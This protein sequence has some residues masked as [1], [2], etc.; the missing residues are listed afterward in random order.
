MG[1]IHILRGEL[2]QGQDMLFEALDRYNMKSDELKACVDYVC[3]N[4]M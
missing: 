1:K 2:Q 3:M 4:E